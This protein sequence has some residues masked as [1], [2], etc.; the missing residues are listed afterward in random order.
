ME[1]MVPAVAS[2]K[3]NTFFILCI[4]TPLQCV[5][6]FVLHQSYII[7]NRMWLFVYFQAEELFRRFTQVKVA[8]V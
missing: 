3:G 7:I 5:F 1:V 4:I 2:K 6:R 8:I